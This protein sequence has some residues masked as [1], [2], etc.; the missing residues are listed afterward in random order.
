MGGGEEDDGDEVLGRKERRRPPWS[1]WAAVR[2]GKEKEMR[3]ER[4][5]ERG[6]VCWASGGGWVGAG[7]C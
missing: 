6:P 3:A 1:Y 4:K 2:N 5:E 7:W